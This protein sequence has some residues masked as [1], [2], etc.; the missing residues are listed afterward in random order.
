MNNNPL[1]SDA[2]L[3]EL[4]NDA[5]IGWWE[6]DFGARCYRCSGFIR[7][8]LGLGED[9]IISFEDFRGFIR[10]DYRVRTLNLFSF[11][12][13]RNVYDEAYPIVVNGQ[14]IW[15]RIKLCSQHKDAKGAILKT[16]G[17]LECLDIDE[18]ARPKSSDRRRLDNLLTQL[19]GISF[20]LQSLLR[21]P[22][23]GFVVNKIL[24]EIL[25]AYSAGC[26]YIV[27][28][29]REKKTQSCR[30][31]AG[32]P[33]A[34]R[35]KDFVNELPMAEI[36][37]WTQRLC[38]EASPI[39][40]SDVDELPDEAQN[41]KERLE[42]Q[43]VRSTIVI[44][45]LSKQGVSG[46]AGIDLLEHH[47]WTNEDYQWFASLVN[48]IS[49]CMDLR[50]SEAA[51]LAEKQYL[52]DLYKHMPIG[53]VRVRLLRD[54]LGKPIDYVFVDTNDM[55]LSIYDAEG[56]CW[57]GKRGS[58]LRMDFEDR[59][60]RL[61]GVGKSGM[62][63]DETLV[64]SS[65]KYCHTVIYSPTKDEFVTLFS[66]M[67]ELFTAH[68]ALD[69]SE[70]I[71]RNIYKNLPVGIELYDKDGYLT[72]LND[73]EMEIFGLPDKEQILGINLFDNPLLPE[74]MKQKLRR[75]ENADFSNQ[76]DFSKLNGYYA[77]QR[78][79]KVNIL[80]RITPL[81]DSQG[82]LMNYLFINVDR[83]ETTVAYNKIQEFQDLFALVGDYAKVGYAHF[84]AISR[85]GDALDTWYRNVGEE[86]GTPLSE[87]IRV[88]TNFHPDDRQDML[89][90]FDRVLSGEAMS[91]RQD[92]RI[93]RPGGVQTWT[94][95]NVLVRDFRPQDGVVEMLCINYDVTEVKN[96]EAKL[97]RAKEKAEESDRLKSAFLA[98]MSH[99]IR[100]PLNAIVGFSNLLAEST[101]AE[102]RRQY[103]G[104]V[105]ENNELLL[106]LISDILD[107]SKIE[108]GT[109]EIVPAGMDAVQMCR[110]LVATTRGKVQPGVE[111]RL[112]I[113]DDECR[114][115]CDRN[116]LTQVLANFLNNAAKFTSSG[117]IALGYRVREKEIE[118]HVSDTGIGIS[119]EMQSRIFDRFVKLNTF[120]NGTGLG[121]SICQSIVRQMNGRIG[122][123]SEPGKGSRFW[124]LLPREAPVETRP[125]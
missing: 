98:N 92:M 107:L 7:D 115:V 46:Y 95:V 101:E 77:T 89:D 44:P 122:V 60:E 26:T 57:T 118:F 55:A 124:V 64:L 12:K 80:S 114:I 66:D 84:D 69:R 91:L 35:K 62:P 37:W 42:K 4:L 30:Y 99:E 113:P 83:T 86:A 100:T 111:L 70:K 43:G 17:L 1:F 71:L 27:E 52:T 110:D 97:I 20:S 48:I 90:F 47:E 63:S 94:R 10:E 40:L 32:T 81:Y 36:P 49:L 61:V 106:Q 67:T 79:D 116:R 78:R 50:R 105:E 51:A 22:D 5:R 21:A 104:I 29:D 19:N 96:T 23:M 56:Q 3:R 73:K 24:G 103:L 31:E 34:A 41:E 11:G 13:N 58:E 108:A 72:D 53:Y 16:S 119:S 25:Q 68:D 125:S 28:Y 38:T 102:E 18:K 75:R 88:H 14:D 117:H 85:K 112:E 74:E 2:H 121:L 54:E 65:G 82:E 59:F 123:E 8:L 45:M 15:V 109:F 93:M 9:G 120:V 87:I 33:G 6:A 76:Y 39:I